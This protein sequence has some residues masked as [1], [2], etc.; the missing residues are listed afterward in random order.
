M[1]LACLRA[2]TSMLLVKGACTHPQFKIASFS[3][4]VQLYGYMTL[5]AA[6]DDAGFIQ[7]KFTIECKQ[8]KVPCP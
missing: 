2:V 5:S 1:H 6:Y 7:S 4:D 8:L 3:V